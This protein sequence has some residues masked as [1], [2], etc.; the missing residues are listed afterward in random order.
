MYTYFDENF[1]KYILQCIFLDCFLNDKVSRQ[2]LMNKS[3]DEEMQL[4]FN[5]GCCLL[6]LLFV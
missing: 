5:T 2:D 3:C 1:G 4:T 6:L